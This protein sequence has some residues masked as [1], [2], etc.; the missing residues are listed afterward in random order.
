M[1][2][3]AIKSGR[4]DKVLGD[5]VGSPKKDAAALTAA[6]YRYYNDGSGTEEYGRLRVLPI[7]MQR[8]KSPTQLTRSPTYAR[9]AWPAPTT[10]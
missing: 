2:T 1:I 6:P 7:E 5:S 8:Q 9:K 10:I 4:V 3:G